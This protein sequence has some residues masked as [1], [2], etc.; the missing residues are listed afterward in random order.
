MY[1][2]TRIGTTTVGP[3]LEWINQPC[4]PHYGPS[5]AINPSLTICNQSGSRVRWRGNIPRIVDAVSIP[6]ISYLDFMWGCCRYSFLSPANMGLLHWRPFES[7]GDLGRVQCATSYGKGST[8]RLVVLVFKIHRMDAICPAG[9]VY[10]ACLLFSSCFL[11]GE[12]GRRHP[13]WLFSRFPFPSLWP[14]ASRH[15]W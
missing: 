6:L 13:P 8:K 4:V 10:S 9:E 15:C 14:S 5:D 12:E 1:Y 11:V 3:W 7:R 2:M